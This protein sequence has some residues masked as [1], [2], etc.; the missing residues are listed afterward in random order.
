[1]SRQFR[2]PRP[3]AK[4][5]MFPFQPNEGEIDSRGLFVCQDLVMRSKVLPL[6]RFNPATAEERPFGHGTAFRIDPWS[7]CATA[8]HVLQDLFQVNAGDQSNLILR[9]DI[10]LVALQIT[11]FGYGIYRPIASAW[12]PISG[13][14][15]VC[16]LESPPFQSPRIRNAT[17]LMMLEIRP[18]Q[19]NPPQR[20]TCL[21]T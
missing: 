13:A 21:S 11:G 7:R 19:Q 5:S 18:S 16:S 6:F 1:M 15:S 3:E 10:R 17:E 14:Y 2:L 12:L 8:F 20:L 9:D 4:K